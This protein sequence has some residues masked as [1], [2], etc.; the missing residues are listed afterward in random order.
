MNK[1]KLPSMVEYINILDVSTNTETDTQTLDRIIGHKDFLT[2]QPNISM[3][4]PA[5]EENG[6]WRVLEEP[7]NWKQWLRKETN[8]SYDLDLIKYERYQNAIDN[9]IFEGFVV[10][11]G[12]SICDEHSI[13]HVFWNYE[14]KWKLSQGINTLEDLTK[15]NLTLTPKFAKELGL[16]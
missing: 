7:K 10:K 8:V 4:V 2:Q 3:F 16:I 14:G 9:V 12:L 13:L 1:I 5:V 11:D 6:E 15:Y